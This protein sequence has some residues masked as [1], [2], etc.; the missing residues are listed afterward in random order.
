ME[1]RKVLTRDNVTY[2]L[3]VL[4]AYNVLRPGH[5]ILIAY[6]GRQRYVALTREGVEKLVR[7]FDKFERVEIKFRCNKELA[8]VLSAQMLYTHP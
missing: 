5:F 4:D 2:V 1:C 3:F 8:N 7:S 6:N